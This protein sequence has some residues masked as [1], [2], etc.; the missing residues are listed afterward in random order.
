MHKQMNVAVDPASPSPLPQPLSI[1]TSSSLGLDHNT[2]F[3]DLSQIADLM[4][5]EVFFFF[6]F[7]EDFG[8]FK[9]SNLEIFSKFKDA[10]TLF[11]TLSFVALALTFRS[12]IHFELIFVSV[13]GK[14][15]DQ[16]PLSPHS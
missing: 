11:Y 9:K 13:K 10:N 16:F 14:N 8:A 5:P 3:A 4:R 2:Q 15:R 12:M 7:K 6:N 1:K